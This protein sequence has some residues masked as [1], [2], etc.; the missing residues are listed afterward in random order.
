MELQHHQQL[1]A[2]MVAMHIDALE[3]L[4]PETLHE[5]PVNAAAIRDVLQQVLYHV[6]ACLK[7]AGEV[8]HLDQVL[9]QA[10]AQA[11]TEI[12]DHERSHGG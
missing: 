2:I 11:K 7:S 6:H 1:A 3:Q 8:E 5:L 12:E 9:V 4:T 10:V